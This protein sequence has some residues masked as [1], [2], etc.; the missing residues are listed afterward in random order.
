MGRFVDIFEKFT[1]IGKLSDEELKKG[2]KLGTTGKQFI[3]V[4]GSV[5]YKALKQLKKNDLARDVPKGLDGLSMY[6]RMDYEKM[7]C[8]IGINNSSGYCIKNRELVSVFS[9]QKSAGHAVVKSAISNGAKHLDCFATLHNNK[10]SGSL[11]SL[12]SSHGFKVDTKLTTGELGVP[13]TVQNGVSR[14]VNDNEEV[15]LKNP[16]IIVYMKL[17]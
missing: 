14:F 8:Y 6:K 17:G 13:Y 2:Q 12:Y 5:F 16:N 4:T 15:E 7:K 3:E 1:D 11:F 9:T 10:I